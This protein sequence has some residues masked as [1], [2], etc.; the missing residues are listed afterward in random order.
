M[1]YI[2][3]LASLSYQQKLVNIHFNQR[4][5]MLTSDISY[6]IKQY[7]CLYVSHILLYKRII[8]KLTAV[9]VTLFEKGINIAMYQNSTI[10][11]RIYKCYCHYSVYCRIFNPCQNVD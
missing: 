7:R 2:R 11:I 9:L 5:K 1:V 10:K 4:N 8:F 6:A 3:K